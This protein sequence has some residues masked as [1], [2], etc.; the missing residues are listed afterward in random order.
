MAF[1]AAMGA[2]KIDG[3]LQID[4]FFNKHR[5]VQLYQQAQGDHPDEPA[6]Q[7]AEGDII[8]K[9]TVKRHGVTPR[10]L[11]CPI[12][13]SGSSFKSGN[14]WIVTGVMENLSDDPNGSVENRY[15]RAAQINR[16]GGWFY[17]YS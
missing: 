12:V 3:V 16:N 15:D 6:K 1:P 9:N 2:G 5:F 14:R 10:V 11:D 8:K 17:S 4:L 7:S 13:Q